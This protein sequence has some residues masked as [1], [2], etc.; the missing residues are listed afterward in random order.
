MILGFFMLALQNK[1]T[2]QGCAEQICRVSRKMVS[3]QAIWSRISDGLIRFLML[4]LKFETSHQVSI[5]AKQVKMHPVLKRFK[6]ILLQDS[7][8]LAQQANCRRRK[9][10]E[11][12]DY[13]LQHS[14][15]Y[16]ELLG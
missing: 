7:T 10:R 16:Y 8:T 4:A 3:K 6:R 2:L 1:N 13:R 15:E 9:A 12:R 14:K 5:N 11:D